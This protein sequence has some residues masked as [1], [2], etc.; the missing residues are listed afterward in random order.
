M[1]QGG[2]PLTL[3]S[4]VVDNVAG[5]SETNPA[6]CDVFPDEHTSTMGNPSISPELSWTGIP[7]ETKS[8][9]VTLHDLTY[10][11]PHWVIWNIPSNQTALQ[12][13]IPKDSAM[14]GTVPGSRQS[15]ATFADG[16]GYFGPTSPCNVYQFEL[17]A[18]AIETFSPTNEEYAAVAKAE[19]EE[20]G[21]AILAQATLTARGNA[22][23]EC[24]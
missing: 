16:D 22:S 4:P 1:P 7:P 12:A 5:C 21:D 24:Q 2:G 6:P 17:F 14:P 10:G 11:Q 19:L 13:N 20:L 3:T 23:M 9:A 8:F 18:L 15:S